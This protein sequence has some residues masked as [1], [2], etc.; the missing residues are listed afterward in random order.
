MLA[1]SNWTLFWQSVEG[2]WLKAIILLI[3]I[4][5]IIIIAAIIRSKKA[6]TKNKIVK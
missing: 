6:K 2:T 3:A 4:I 5:L 1:T